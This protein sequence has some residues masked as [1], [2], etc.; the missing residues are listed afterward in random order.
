MEVSAPR[1]LR[2]V[3]GRE[4]L[5]LGPCVVKHVTERWALGRSP[6]AIEYENLRDLARDGIPVP[7][8]LSWSAER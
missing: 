1:V 5:A 3:P 7:R 6:G 8:A 4:T 2:S